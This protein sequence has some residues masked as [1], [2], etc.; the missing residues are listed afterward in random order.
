MSLA[1]RRGRKTRRL[2]LIGLAGLALGGA[3]VLV[4]YALGDKITYAPTPTELAGGAHDPGARI[5]LGGLV[6]TGSLT[7][8]ADGL[9]NF[10]VT[11][12][13]SRIPVTYVGILPDLFREGQGVVAEGILGSDGTLEADTVLARHDENYMPKEVVDSLKAQG[14]WQDGAMTEGHVNAQ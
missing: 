13:K 7:Q 1:P 14:R 4:F 2:A 8:G 5:R 10:A 3:A 9:V 6:E 11:D 12:T